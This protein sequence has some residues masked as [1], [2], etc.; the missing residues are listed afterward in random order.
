MI[1]IKGDIIKQLNELYPEFSFRIKYKNELKER[2]LFFVETKI[3]PELSFFEKIKEVSEHIIIENNEVK[4]IKK[5][6]INKYKLELFNSLNPNWMK[7][8]IQ[9]ETIKEKIN[10]IKEEDKNDYSLLLFDLF[11]NNI[12]KN[13]KFNKIEISEI[14]KDFFRKETELNIIKERTYQ[15][16]KIKI[17]SFLN[18]DFI[19]GIEDIE[20]EVKLLKIKITNKKSNEKIKVEKIT[21]ILNLFLTYLYLKKREENYLLVPITTYKEGFFNNKKYFQLG[22]VLSTEKTD[23][24]NILREGKENYYAVDK[25]NIGIATEK[26][27]EKINE[28]KGKVEIINFIIK[29]VTRL[30]EKTKNK[31]IEIEELNLF[32]RNIE[33]E[34]YW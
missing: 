19:K 23:G 10:N 14:I 29:N 15:K 27:K 25:F 8:K 1:R 34:Y 17:K 6:F 4:Q 16:E 2:I 22:G 30:E 20:K 3:T 33:N 32:L 13:K 21:E 5:E 9:K 7:K 31:E 24:E 28:K 26:L 18:I 12:F 11:I